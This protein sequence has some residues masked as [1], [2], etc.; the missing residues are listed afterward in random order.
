MAPEIVLKKDYSGFATD[1]WSLGIILFVI[2]SGTYPFK[3]QNEKDLFSKI[4]RGMFHMPEFMPFEAK[5][6]I[7][8]MLAIDP[9]KRPNAK[10][11]CADRWLGF[12]RAVTGMSSGG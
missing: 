11:L 6:L 12:P 9:A 8:R 4:S 3:G 2:L 1:I 10:E 5:R 7:T